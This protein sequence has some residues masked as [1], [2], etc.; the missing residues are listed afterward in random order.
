MDEVT[1]V[2]VSIVIPVYKVS[3]YIADCLRSVCEQTYPH[4]EVI[5]VND[6]TPDDSMEQAAPWIQKMQEQGYTVR[7][8]N[9][10]ENKGLS[11][12]RNTGIRAATTDWVYFL[13]SD[14]ELTPQCIEW[15]V[16]QVQLH[17]SVDFVIGGIKVVGSHWNYPLTCRPYAGANREILQDYAAAKWYVMAVNHL[18]RK[19]YLLQHNL[20]FR[21]GLLHEDLLYSFHVAITA[22]AMAT[23]YKE[24]YVYKVRSAGSI[25]GQLTL[26]NLEDMLTINIEKIDYILKQ[27]QTND[28]SLPFSYCL[29]ITYWFMYC[30]VESKEIDYRAKIHLLDSMRVKYLSISSY[31]SNLWNMK[32]KLLYAILM[33][34]TYFI[35]LCI[36]CMFVLRKVQK[37][38]R[39]GIN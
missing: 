17:S 13:D 12:A 16:E 30:A 28:Y 4:I 22:Q 15:M 11:A 20:Y 19:N 31:K 24:T 32:Y 34:P 29:D 38:S 25:T 6:A 8:V 9:H 3:A 10:P 35:F 27:Y 39:K 23:V 21:E 26:K 5:L 14:D 1:S 7:V 18:Y 33:Q 2:E 36:K 37:L